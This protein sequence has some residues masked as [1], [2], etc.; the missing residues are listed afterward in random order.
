MI[1]IRVM[2]LRFESGGDGVTFFKSGIGEVLNVKRP[3]KA[4]TKMLKAFV[5]CEY[6]SA[7]LGGRVKQGFLKVARFAGMVVHGRH[8]FASEEPT[9]GIANGVATRSCFVADASDL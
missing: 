3:F 1:V 7:G 4:G 2:S 9:A 8:G 5:G 6:D